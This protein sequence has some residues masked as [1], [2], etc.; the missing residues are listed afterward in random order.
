MKELLIELYKN[1]IYMYFLGMLAGMSLDGLIIYKYIKKG[2]KKKYA[3]WNVS[4]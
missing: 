4:R 3:G 2:E 1:P